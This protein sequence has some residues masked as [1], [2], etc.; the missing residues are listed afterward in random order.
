[1][2]V[3]AEAEFDTEADAT[4]KEADLDS[5]RGRVLCFGTDARAEGGRDGGRE[6]KSREEEWE[7]EDR[8][9]TGKR[10]G[11]RWRWKKEVGLDYEE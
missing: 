8:G 2:A 1:M 6:R 3:A 7:E 9:G 10:N 4:A 5:L 11:R